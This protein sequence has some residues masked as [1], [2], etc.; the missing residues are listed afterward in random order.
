MHNFI[1]MYIKKTLF[2]AGMVPLSGL[3]L[4][5]SIYNMVIGA[6]GVGGTYDFECNDGI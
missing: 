1:K 4:F 3:G 2:S 5:N 6:L